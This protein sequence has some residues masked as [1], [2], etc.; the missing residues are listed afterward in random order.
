M[1]QGRVGGKPKLER[2]LDQG[3]RDF[4]YH[5]WTEEGGYRRPGIGEVLVD[6]V[7]LKADLATPPPI[8]WVRHARDPFGHSPLSEGACV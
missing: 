2:G 8:I 1:V 6:A 7:G 3:W 5:F 4:V